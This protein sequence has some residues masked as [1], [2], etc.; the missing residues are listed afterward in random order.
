[1]RDIFMNFGS[2]NR[3]SGV[4]GEIKSSIEGCSQELRSIG[5]SINL[6]KAGEQIKSSL[7]QMSSQCDAHAQRIQRM[8]NTMRSAS[9]IMQKA[10][11]RVI[12]KNILSTMPGEFRGPY[13]NNMINDNGFISD[14][15]NRG[16]IMNR[17]YGGDPI[18]M[19]SGNLLWQ[20]TP[21]STYSGEVLDFTVF[22]DSI[23]ARDDRMGKG[24]RH[25]FMAEVM[26]L[27]QKLWAFI[28][29]GG[30]AR[31]FA[32]GDDG[33][34]YPQKPT[35]QR[36]VRVEDGFMYYLPENQLAYKFN[37][38][39]KLIAL[40]NKGVEIQSIEYDE[41]KPV[42]VS[43]QHGYFYKLH[44]DNN[45]YLVRLEDNIGRSIKFEYD[46]TKLCSISICTENESKSKKS[47][48]NRKYNFIYDEQGYLTKV[49]G[50]EDRTFFTNVYD[51][52]GR[53]I[54]QEL[55]GERYFDFIYEEGKT[56]NTDQDGFSVE[57]V[58]DKR[59]N[60]IH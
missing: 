2:V 42:K 52:Y 43:G 50:P 1:M 56:V 37:K 24:W 38:N 35:T 36:L 46:A 33:V 34:F 26:H 30:V 7:N 53:V 27:D 10:E 47:Y 55:S 3:L 32:E 57:Y 41:D 49:T 11:N 9:E 6:G 5:S 19:Y 51:K 25:N 14:L 39:G 29:A 45:A 12:G 31:L 16:Q 20:F 40:Y 28:D 48:D 22:Y 4:A 60:L 15:I 21:I 8:G 18:S 58:H 44:Y 23:N 54:R 17:G 59:G 13:F